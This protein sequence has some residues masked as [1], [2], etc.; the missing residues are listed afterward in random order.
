M[1]SLLCSGTPLRALCLRLH[2]ERLVRGRELANN[3][4]RIVALADGRVLGEQVSAMVE[5][6]QIRDA[7][8]MGSAYLAAAVEATSLEGAPQGSVG[9]AT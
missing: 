7:S 5:L 2:G 3:F 1:R 9:V 4:A 8:S 6:K